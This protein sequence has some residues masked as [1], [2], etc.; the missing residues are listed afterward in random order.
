MD[1]VDEPRSEL[2][3]NLGD[4]RGS[5]FKSLERCEEGFVPLI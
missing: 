3:D 2:Q 4:W 1:K 5:F